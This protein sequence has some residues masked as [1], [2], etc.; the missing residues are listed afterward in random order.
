M[1]KQEFLAQ[2]R[3]G[4]YGL[5]QEDIDERV[6]FYSEMIDDQMEEGLSEE[7]AVCGIGSVATIISQIVAGVPLTKLVKERIKPKKGL[8]V[9]EIILLALGAPIWLSLA[10]SAFAVMLS[11]YISLWSVI[12]SLW[13]VFASLIGCALG[14]IAAGIG[15]AF[16]GSGP[17]GIAMIGA[18]V[19]CAGLAIFLF[20]G[21]RSATKGILLLTKKFVLWTKNCFMKREEA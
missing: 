20:F 17:V 6:F 12:I 3:I 14:G 13:A 5:P 7:E 1:S 2:L 11:L 19:F 9:W 16:A 21:C 18:S 8:R 4:L 15:F 10:V